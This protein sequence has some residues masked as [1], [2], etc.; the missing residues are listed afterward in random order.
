VLDKNSVKVGVMGGGYV[1][2][3]H[4]RYSCLLGP[5][6]DGQYHEVEMQGLDRI[7]TDYP[8][9]DLTRLWKEGDHAMG[10]TQRWPKKLGGG[11][12]TMLIGIKSPHLL[13][14]LIMTLPGGL[15][16]YA[17][18]LTDKYGSNLCFGGPH[19]V[20][21]A[22]FAKLKEDASLHQVLLTGCAGSYLP[23]PVPRVVK[24]DGSEK[25]LLPMGV[26]W[27]SPPLAEC[28]KEEPSVR[29]GVESGE[30]RGS[31]GTSEHPQVRKSTNQGT[32]TDAGC[33]CGVVYGNCEHAIR[34]APVI[35]NTCLKASAP[36]SKLEGLEDKTDISMTVEPRLEPCSSRVSRELSRK[37]TKSLQEAHK[38]ES[39]KRSNRVALNSKQVSDKR[40]HFKK[41]VV[42]RNDRV[43]ESLRWPSDTSQLS[44][45]QQAR[46][47][48]CTKPAVEALTKGRQSYHLHSNVR[49]KGSCCCTEMT[50]GQT[51]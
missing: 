49:F 29:A 41:P 46:E 25:F 17:S 38:Q 8:E 6:A 27:R 36:L 45:L 14:R 51:Q 43:S 7:T 26:A 30:D 24:D 44:G 42:C 40:R 9:I 23:P 19:E 28:L 21:S 5:D 33:L 31:Q 2:T 48:G 10:T 22:A 3:N 32:Q 11:R 47:V 37:K 18:K 15:Q 12:V 34:S 4:G 1:E 35:T 20:F 39:T 13:P 50:G 16:I